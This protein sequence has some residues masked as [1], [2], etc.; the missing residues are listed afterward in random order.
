MILPLLLHNINDIIT[1]L[2]FYELKIIALFIHISSKD[3]LL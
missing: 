2:V 1:L 3:K